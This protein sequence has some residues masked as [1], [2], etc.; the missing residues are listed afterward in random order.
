MRC[1]IIVV[2]ANLSGE[3]PALVAPVPDVRLTGN[4]SGAGSRGGRGVLFT[5]RKDAQIDCQTDKRFTKRGSTI[6]F[7]RGCYII[8]RDTI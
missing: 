3:V 6:S 1:D 2:V 8:D 7:Y 4:L 5:G